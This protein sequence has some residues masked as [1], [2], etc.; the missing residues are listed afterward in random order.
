MNIH[1]IEVANNFS[2]LQDKTWESGWWRLEENVAKQLVGGEIY[3]HRKKDE[4][5]FYGG[6]ITGYRIEQDGERRGRIVFILQ[7]SNACRNIR[8][9]R[10][11]WSREMKLISGDSMSA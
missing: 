10:Q 7:P 3:F 8:T 5:S 11:G 1:L 2:R 4:P 9:D 6:T